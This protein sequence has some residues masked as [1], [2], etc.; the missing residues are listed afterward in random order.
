MVRRMSHTGFKSVVHVHF[1]K[2]EGAALREHAERRLLAGL[3]DDGLTPSRGVRCQALKKRE[4]RLVRTTTKRIDA[5]RRVTL[6]K[7]G[8]GFE[9][10]PTRQYP[11]RTWSRNESYRARGCGI[12]Y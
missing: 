2:A 3:W 4:P 12:A 1:C 8:Y 6:K 9:N 10:H 5:L 11:A 7:G